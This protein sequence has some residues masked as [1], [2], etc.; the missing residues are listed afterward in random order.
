MFPSNSFSVCK[1]TPTL[2]PPADTLSSLLNGRA[3]LFNQR[4]Q[5]IYAS[6]LAKFVASKASNLTFSYQTF[7]LFLTIYK[8]QIYLT[9]NL[10]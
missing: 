3:G 6:K 7:I 8:L 2:S 9:T 1:K 10:L 4:I 5:F